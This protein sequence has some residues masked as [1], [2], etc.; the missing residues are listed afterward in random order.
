MLDTK[1]AYE[2]LLSD[3]KLDDL[4]V[5][6]KEKTAKLVSLSDSAA[7]SVAVIDSQVAA[8]SEKAAQ[9]QQDLQQILQERTEKRAEKRAIAAHI[10]RVVAKLS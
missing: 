7:D 1:A 8:V 6:T 3:P 10:T 9:A 4:L 5:R 2:S